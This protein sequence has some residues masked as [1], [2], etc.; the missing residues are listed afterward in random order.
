MW[1]DTAAAIHAA[2]AT[3]DRDTD[4]KRGVT[5]S[6]KEGASCAAAAPRMPLLAFRYPAACWGAPLVLQL[7]LLLLRAQRLQQARG[8]PA[9]GLLEDAHCAA[10]V[11]VVAAG[12][13]RAVPSAAE[14]GP[15]HAAAAELPLLPLRPRSSCGSGRGGSDECGLQRG[16]EEAPTNA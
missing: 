1:R 16:K 15:Q 14:H 13:L 7:V 3:N 9:G 5:L 10:A 12:V 8:S 6:L 2:A 11:A 4:R